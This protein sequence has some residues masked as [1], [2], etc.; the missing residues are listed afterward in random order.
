MA[1]RDSVAL[2]VTV[3]CTVLVSACASSVTSTDPTAQRMVGRWSQVF[4]F[5]DIR[6]EIAIDLQPDATL[7]VNIRRHSGAGIDQYSG[8]GKWRVEEGYFVSQLDFR[9]PAN[10]VDHLIGR[11]RIVS[12]TEWQ[13]VS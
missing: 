6:D 2:V 11:H 10:A 3:A 1:I 8:S 13:W 5:N 7:R 4:S 12:V 9:G